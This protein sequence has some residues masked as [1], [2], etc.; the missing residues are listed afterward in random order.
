MGQK[1]HTNL[2]PGPHLLGF[3]TAFDESRGSPNTPWPYPIVI[4]SAVG[5]VL[6]PFPCPHC[7][8]TCADHVHPTRRWH[9]FDKERKF[10]WCPACRGRFFVDRRG[11]LL[12]EPLAAG[13]LVAP[14]RVEYISEAKDVSEEEVKKVLVAAAEDPKFGMIG[15]L[16]LTSGS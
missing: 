8:K 12:V 6:L 14:A 1:P 11:Q 9:H 16:L 15:S 2:I 3:M 10:C 4:P 5:S 7:K 13:S